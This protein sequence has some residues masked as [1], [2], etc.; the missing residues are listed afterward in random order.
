MEDITVYS[1][2]TRAEWFLVLNVDK[3]SPGVHRDYFNLPR[4]KGNRLFSAL[5]IRIEKTLFKDEAD[6]LVGFKSMNVEFG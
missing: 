1:D 5:G 4:Y 3:M 6:L 2:S